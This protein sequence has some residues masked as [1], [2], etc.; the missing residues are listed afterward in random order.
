MGSIMLTLN[1]V[2]VASYALKNHCSFIGGIPYN[3]VIK[4]VNGKLVFM[5]K[6][7]HFG[8]EFFQWIRMNFDS[9]LYEEKALQYKG[10]TYRSI[11]LT[12]PQKVQTK[13]LLSFRQFSKNSNQLVT[14]FN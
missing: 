11:F 5:F 8:N 4:G 12:V 9:N 2:S 14:F 3:S 1:H 10:I 6:P 13:F 7:Q